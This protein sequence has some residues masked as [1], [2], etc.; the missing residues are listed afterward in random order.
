MFP[1]I[2]KWVS[3]A[4]LV[5]AI[6]VR[7]FAPQYSVIPQLV[8]FVGASIVFLQGVHERKSEWAAAFAVIA[9]FFNPILIL[10]PVA[11]SHFFLL[12]AASMTVFGLAL[13]TLTTPPLRSMPSITDRTPGSESL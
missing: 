7:G 12:V 4:A 3:L 13:A 6:A 11:S 2:M 8:I 9:V 5:A 1:K 10:V